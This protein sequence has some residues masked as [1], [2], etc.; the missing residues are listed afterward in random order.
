[1]KYDEEVL[2][3]PGVLYATVSGKIERARFAQLSKQS[4]QRAHDSGLRLLLDFTR[5]TNFSPTPIIA[6]NWFVE[7]YDKIDLYL[8]WVPTAHL[9]SPKDLEFFTFVELSWTNRGAIVRAF[10][11][12]VAALEWLGGIRTRTL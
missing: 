6:H 12:R 7:Y 9:V 2:T 1:M 3:S 5:A 11:D 10:T 8:K 4:R